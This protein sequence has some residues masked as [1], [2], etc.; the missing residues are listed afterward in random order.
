[1]DNEGEKF[2]A[3]YLEVS[4][5][6]KGRPLSVVTHLV[7]LT[8]YLEKI[9]FAVKPICRSLPSS[10]QS[11]PMIGR[12]LMRSKEE[13]TYFTSAK[14][15]AMKSCRMALEACFSITSLQISF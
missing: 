10:D 14:F 4:C 5:P 3:A 11:I 1:M 8:P 13:G 12:V 7:P 6:V 9:K 15:R 2:Q